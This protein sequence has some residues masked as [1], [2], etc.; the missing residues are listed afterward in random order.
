MPCQDFPDEIANNMR[1]VNAQTNQTNTKQRLDDVT[2]L[3]CAVLTE[4]DYLYDAG[5][6]SKGVGSF[7]HIEGLEAWWTEH[8]FQDVLREA[9]EKEDK[10]KRLAKIR[11][12]LKKL[13]KFEMI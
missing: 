7:F 13:E 1:Q 3:L 11:D 2:R 5:L 8:L 6:I 10:V 12:D 9:A 4:I